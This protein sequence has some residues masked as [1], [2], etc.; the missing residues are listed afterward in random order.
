MKR[1]ISADK[2]T[3]LE[4]RVAYFLV[5]Y[6]K[7]CKKYGMFIASK[8][9]EPVLSFLHNGKALVD[10]LVQLMRRAYGMDCREEADYKT[11]EEVVLS[12]LK[13]FGV[14]EEGC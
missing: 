10:H 12:L 9:G 8:E 2:H 11:V 7:V 5:E 4:M 13:D 3:K 14:L 1:E 6:A